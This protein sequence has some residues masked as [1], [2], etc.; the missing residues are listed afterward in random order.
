MNIKLPVPRK[1]ER[2][3]QEYPNPAPKPQLSRL[4]DPSSMLDNQSCPIPKAA[5]RS[6][7]PDAS[8][9]STSPLG[10]GSEAAPD[11][12]VQKFISDHFPSRNTSVSRSKLALHDEGRFLAI[13]SPALELSNTGN[14]RPGMT[15]N[16]VRS[17]AKRILQHL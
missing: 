10:Q 17:P 3:L 9:D 6:S 7:S 13:M 11:F 5:Q 2:A 16:A 12:M 14:V 15:N 1:G 4:L 8:L